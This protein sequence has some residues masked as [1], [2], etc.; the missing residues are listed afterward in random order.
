MVNTST[1][2]DSFKIRLYVM[3]SRRQSVDLYSTT[4]PNDLQ[5]ACHNL[6]TLCLLR[7]TVLQLQKLCTSACIS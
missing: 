2:L 7:S 3:L 4:S 5:C 6:S 1:D